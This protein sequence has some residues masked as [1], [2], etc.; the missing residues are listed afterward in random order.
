MTGRFH[1][2]S[3]R[4]SPSGGRTAFSLRPVAIGLMI[5]GVAGFIAARV[6]FGDQVLCLL[7]STLVT[8]AGLAMI[9]AARRRLREGF[10]EQEP[11]PQTQRPH[12][13]RRPVT[14]AEDP[15]VEWMEQLGRNQEALSPLAG[16]AS[17]IFRQQGAQVVL[18]AQQ[19][20]RSILQIET[21]EG[22]RYTAM[23]LEGP[24][25]ADAAEVRGLYALAT[26][27]GVDGALLVSGGGFTPRAVQWSQGKP[28]RL[29]KGQ[30]LA[31]LNI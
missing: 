17:A 3:Q 12:P 13:S 30:G 14:V 2:T 19:D 10:Q 27:A 25:P 20:D 28:I 22:E 7:G 15:A 29:V 5:A 11:E 9:L 18:D 21:R 6:M 31:D 8:F 1:P 16:R 24:H 26:S 4:G 23:I